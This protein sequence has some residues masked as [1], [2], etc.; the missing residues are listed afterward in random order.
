MLLEC[1][2][3]QL[4]RVDEQQ[5]CVILL[6]ES[7]IAFE[8]SVESRIQLHAMA[9]TS[10]GG[11]ASEFLPAPFRRLSCFLA[12]RTGRQKTAGVQKSV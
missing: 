1:H 4:R 5:P 3:C 2:G 9:S 11:Q 7:V 12:G 8:L 10:V 6:L